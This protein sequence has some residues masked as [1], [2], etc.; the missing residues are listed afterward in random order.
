MGL[1]WII[2]LFIYLQWI[3]ST[4][5]GVFD[6]CC[7]NNSA[8]C[9]SQLPQSQPNATNRMRIAFFADQGLS[10][11][12]GGANPDAVKVLVILPIKLNFQCDSVVKK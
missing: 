8:P 10:A 3:Q 12:Y 2:L 9:I 6:C 5:G 7:V 1:P 4:I 11:Q